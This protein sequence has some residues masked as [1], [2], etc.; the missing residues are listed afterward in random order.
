[1]TRMRGA[2]IAGASALVGL[3]RGADGLTMSEASFRLQA[4]RS[5]AGKLT[6]S[7]EL[8]KYPKVCGRTRSPRALGRRPSSP[9]P[10]PPLTPT[11]LRPKVDVMDIPIDYKD[12]WEEM[13]LSCR[14][15]VKANCLVAQEG[16]TLETVVKEQSKAMG[17]FP[18]PCPVLFAPWDK[19]R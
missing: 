6:L 17:D 13:S 3:C 9:S 1:M 2:C 5:P 19:V 10:P 7:V 4:L 15:S 11:T 12:Q 16:E 18:G 14:T 8:D